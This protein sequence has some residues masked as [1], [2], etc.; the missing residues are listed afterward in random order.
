MRKRHNF[1]LDD[2][3]KIAPRTYQDAAYGACRGNIGL[4]PYRVFTEKVLPEDLL[5]GSDYFD[6][7]DYQSVRQEL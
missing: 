4:E 2:K 7:V 3:E 5:Q 1:L 6:D